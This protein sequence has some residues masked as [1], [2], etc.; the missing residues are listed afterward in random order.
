[1][2]KQLSSYNAFRNHLYSMYEKTVNKQERSL[3]KNRKNVKSRKRQEN[4]REN[5]NDATKAN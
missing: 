2:I 3:E 1:M 4:V 5:I